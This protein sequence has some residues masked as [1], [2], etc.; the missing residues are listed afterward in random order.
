MKNKP[1]GVAAAGIPPAGAGAAAGRFRLVRYFS[2]TALLAFAVVGV[3]LYLLER[4]ESVYFRAV[5][6][7]QSRFVEHVQQEFARQQEIAARRDLLAIHEAGHVNLTRLMANALWASHI[8]PL[9]ARVEQMRVEECHPG[10]GVSNAGIAADTTSECISRLGKRIMSLTEFAHLDSTLARVMRD[11]TVFKVKV[12]DR[13]GVTA[14]SSE[15]AQ[16][17]EDKRANQGWLA[18]ARGQAASELTHR[19]RFS[20]FEGVVENRDLISSYVPV[21]APGGKTVLGVFEIYSDVTPFLEQIRKAARSTAELAATN[22]IKLAH[23]AAENQKQVD[24]S[25]DVLLSIVGGLLLLLYGA[26]LLIVLR[27]Q[28]II[29]AQADAQA[30]L[31]VREKRWHREKMSALAAMAAS[32]SHEIGNPLAMITVVAED[33]ASRKEDG[34]CRECHPELILEQVRRISQKTR[35]ISDFAAARSEVLEPVDT[36]QMVRSICDF[37][38]FD[39]RFRSVS[40]DFRASSGLGA[41]E[42]VPD[43]LTEALMNLLEWFA[44][45]EEDGDALPRALVVETLGDDRGVLIRISRTADRQDAGSPRRTHD[46]RLDIALRRIAEMGGQFSESGNSI[47]IELPASR[48]AAG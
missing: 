35:Q 16:V 1:E 37:L 11:S 28:R 45:L 31:A 18:A 19:D 17:G 23:S 43:H 7:S 9:V 2:F 44:A 25:S 24:A 36:N 26:L 48:T 8:A 4:E 6:D 22:R 40:I 47:E 13:R 38:A 42:I 21:F 10:G 46:S 12:F 39:R 14:Y 41:P 27:A 29:D 5:Q 20:A 32:V 33:I 30:A 3:V 15:H 34:D